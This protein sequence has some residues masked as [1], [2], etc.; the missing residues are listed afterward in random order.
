[1]SYSSAAS[2]GICS[3][4]HYS[5]E[6]DFETTDEKMSAH[7]MHVYRMLIGSFLIIDN[8]LKSEVLF[9]LFFYVKLYWGSEDTRDPCIFNLYHESNGM[10]SRA[11]YKSLART[12]TDIAPMQIEEIIEH[13]LLIQFF[14]QPLLP[15]DAKLFDKMNLYH[16]LSTNENNESFPYTFLNYVPKTNNNDDDDNHN[17]KV[18]KLPYNY[19][20]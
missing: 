15:G 20:L 11:K 7:E 3:L 19:S 2:D 10:R 5:G 4:S 12:L 13:N 18:K 8:A 17:S 14:I 6:P 16:T 1:M 9:D